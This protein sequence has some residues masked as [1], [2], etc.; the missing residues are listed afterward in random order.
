MAFLKE[1]YKECGHGEATIPASLSGILEAEVLEP[2]ST[3]DARRMIATIK[4]LTSRHLATKGTLLD[5]GAGYGFFARE[6]AQAD[7]AVIAINPAQMEHSLLGSLSGVQSRCCTFEDLEMV[8]NSVSAVLMSHVLEHSLDV[9]LWISKAS[10]ILE[11]GGVVA[12]ALPNFG[13]LQRLILQENE[14]YICPP[15]HLNFFTLDSLKRLLARHRFDVE[16]VQHVSRI[17]RRT[18]EKRLRGVAARL[19]TPAWQLANGVLQ[20]VD[21]AGFGSVVNVYARKPG[22]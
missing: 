21:L 8:S 14:P 11:P 1:Y 7:F 13:S 10:E 20:V 22:S 2:N 19:T 6:A 15:T 18:I 4:R 17:P 9:N 5:V 16:A 12:I 3:L